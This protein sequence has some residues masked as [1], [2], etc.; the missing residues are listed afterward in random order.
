MKDTFDM[1]REVLEIYDKDL[2]SWKQPQKYWDMLNEFCKYSKI[3]VTEQEKSIVRPKPGDTGVVRKGT[4][5][6]DVFHE[7]SM[8]R[9]KKNGI[10]L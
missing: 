1:L 6:W 4:T 3:W 9:L 5:E 8:K 2:P 10:H 7:L